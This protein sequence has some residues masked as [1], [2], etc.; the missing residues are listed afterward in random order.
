MIIGYRAGYLLGLNSISLVV[1]NTTTNAMVVGYRAGYLLGLDAISLVV[2]NT[3]TNAIVVG[4]RAGYLLGTKS[5]KTTEWLFGYRDGYLLGFD[6][7][8]L[9]EP[10]TSTAMVR[11][12]GISTTIQ[13]TIRPCVARPNIKQRNFSMFFGH[14]HREWLAVVCERMRFA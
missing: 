12:A 2:W 3:T 10:G 5:T 9:V 4:Y 11:L 1:W 14:F 7:I 13:P 6:D 8:S